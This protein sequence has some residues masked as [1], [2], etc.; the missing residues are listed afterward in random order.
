M[1]EYIATWKDKKSNSNLDLLI[2][3]NLRLSITCIAAIL[4]A[5][6]APAIAGN[7]ATVHGEVYGWDTFEP[8][9]NAIV[10]INSTP[11][12]FMVAKYGLYSFELTPGDYSITAKYYQ[13]NTLTHSATETIK[14][15]GDGNYVLDLL[16]LP[17]YSEELMNSSG[18]DVFSKNSTSIER[19]TETKSTL[20]KINTSNDVNITEKSGFNF[21]NVNYL[22]IFLMLLI[23]LVGSYQFFGKHKMAK[24]TP[25]SEKTRHEIEEPVGIVKTQELSMKVPYK[26]ID[27]DVMQDFQDDT[28][29]NESTTNPVT[30]LK[31]EILEMKTQAENEEEYPIQETEI[32]ENETELAKLWVE[33]ENI[34]I[35]LEE[36]AENPKIKTPIPEKKLPLPAD[37]QG[38]IDIIRGQGGR[39]TQKNLRSRLKY[40]EGKVSLM[41]ADLEKRELIEKFKRGRGN[42][43]I[44]RDKER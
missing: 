27:P 16:L 42:I 20:H 14:I 11:S 29:E 7:T 5:L 19:K 26:I 17:V 44:L 18:I 22:L 30:K 13:N 38:V 35:S 36:S 43:V 37:L 40:S 31:S 41:L 9:E 33:E 12:Q 1:Y 39:I 4:F 10:D 15:K 3:M 23:L 2:K 25:H 8:L 32:P 24:M 34:K 6:V 21:I 28:E